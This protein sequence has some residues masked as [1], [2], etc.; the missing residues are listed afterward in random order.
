MQKVLADGDS[1]TVPGPNHKV[2]AVGPLKSIIS[3]S[4][5]DDSLFLK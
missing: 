5:L 1:V 3:M 4:S 2:I